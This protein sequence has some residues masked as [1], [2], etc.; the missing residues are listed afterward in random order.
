MGR[1]TKQQI[2]V[3]RLLK[4]GCVEIKSTSAKYRKF[5]HPQDT[6]KFYWAGKHGALRFGRTVG[7]SIPVLRLK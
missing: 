7:E 1:K 6:E 4:F 2:I 3:E 5:K